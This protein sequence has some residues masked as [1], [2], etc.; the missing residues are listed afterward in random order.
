M[1]QLKEIYEKILGKGI[2]PNEKLIQI[3]K[4]IIKQYTALSDEKSDANDTAMGIITK[5]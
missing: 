4:S 3:V 1:N 2:I 5:F